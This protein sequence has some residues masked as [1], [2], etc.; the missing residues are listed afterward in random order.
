[1]SVCCCTWPLTKTNDDRWPRMGLCGMAPLAPSPYPWLLVDPLLLQGQG[2]GWGPPRLA[3]VLL[4]SLSASGTPPGPQ[5]QFTQGGKCSLVFGFTSAPVVLCYGCKPFGMTECQLRRWQRPLLG[6]DKKSGSSRCTM[7]FE[8]MAF[9]GGSVPDRTK[10]YS[11][12]RNG[13]SHRVPVTCWGPVPPVAAAGSSGGWGLLSLP[14]GTLLFSQKTQQAR[15]RTWHWP[16]T[17]CLRHMC[18][19]VQILFVF[20]LNLLGWHCFI[21][22]HRF[23]M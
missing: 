10:G 1:M 23:Q 4:L 14:E 6:H 13:P 16:P 22:L 19:C 11:R 17:N 8:L 7:Y 3:P 2:G 5:R 18:V 15:H 12:N 21:K 9:V 20:L